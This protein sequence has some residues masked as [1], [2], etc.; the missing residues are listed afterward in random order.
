MWGISNI[1]CHNEPT[2][3]LLIE[4]PV[5]E[6][7][8]SFLRHGSVG[9]KRETHF[10]VGNLLTTAEQSVIE[11][12]INQYPGLLRLFIT[13]CQTDAIKFNERCLLL[14]LEN[15]RLLI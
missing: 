9:I 2:A 7:I 3:R 14:V 4:H 1:A 6:R 5:C 8:V 11:S 13:S 15:T 12:L 10:T